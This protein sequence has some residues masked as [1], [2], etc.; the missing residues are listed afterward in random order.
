MKQNYKLFWTWD[1]CTNWCLNMPGNQNC[2]SGNAYTKFQPV[3]LRDYKR[4]V[5]WCAEHGVDGIG[6]VGLLRDKHGGVDTA[7]ELCIFARENGVRIYMIAGLY[8]YGGI[9][10]EGNHPYSLDTFLEKNPEC[11]GR[12]A[13]GAPIRRRFFSPSGGSGAKYGGCPSSEKLHN[14]IL[15]SLDWLFQAIPELGGIQMETADLG[16]C[17]C[18]RCRERYGKL[19]DTPGT[20]SIPDMGRIYPDAVQTILN[21][22]PDAWAI[23]ETY[24]HFLEKNPDPFNFG[25]G[26]P[27]EYLKYLTRIPEQAFLQWVCDQ[28]IRDDYWTDDNRMPEPLRRYRHIMR[29]HYG[30]YWRHE[31]N[32]RHGLSVKHIRKQCRLSYLSGI[33][34]ISIFGESSPFHPNAEFNY[35]AMVYFTDH[36]MASLGEFSD[37]VM[38]PRLGGKGLAE[39]YLD[40]ADTYRAP[41]KIP[42]AEKEIVRLLPQLSDPECIR[43][44]IHLAS[45]LNTFLW[46]SHQLDGKINIY[47]LL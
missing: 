43:R 33:Q 23:C 12:T 47:D 9:Y 20:I 14:F 8:G 15:E 38:A 1:H 13:D 32:T 10:H 26:V 30:T 4:A 28:A 21:R 42:E 3:F 35:L 16:F 34:G 25:Y 39:R 5:L 18:D 7:R 45:F 46:D 17:M 29:A 24:H 2:G 27:P 40:L 37:E 6:I 36:P 41:G 19:P 22:A 31:T 44:W 11:M